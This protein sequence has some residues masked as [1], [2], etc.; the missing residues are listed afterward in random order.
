VIFA[1]ADDIADPVQLVARIG[2]AL[3]A[4]ARR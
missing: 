4:A 1:I 3:S 2:A